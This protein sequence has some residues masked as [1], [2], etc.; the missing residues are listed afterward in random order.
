M[1]FNSNK[2]FSESSNENQEKLN[3]PSNFNNFKNLP[4]NKNLNSINYNNINHHIDNIN[5][6][7]NFDGEAYENYKSS[8]NSAEFNKCKFNIPSQKLY[9]NI[10]NNINTIENYNVEN[11]YIHT[12]NNRNND[13]IINDEI[14]NTRSSNPDLMIS[15]KIKNMEYNFIEYK[16]VDSKTN[17]FSTIK[18]IDLNLAKDETFNSSIK[19]EKVNREENKNKFLDNS[20]T[21]KDSYNNQIKSETNF[22]FN[23]ITENIQNEK[24]SPN[25]N[26]KK[27]ENLDLNINNDFDDNYLKYNSDFNKAL[28]ISGEKLENKIL[29][30]SNEFEYDFEHKNRKDLSNSDYYQRKNSPNFNN[31]MMNNFYADTK[32]I[33]GFNFHNN[34][35]NITEKDNENEVN[36]KIFKNKENEINMKIENSIIPINESY[37]DY[38]NNYKKDLD[39]KK[40]LIDNS[41]CYILFEKLL[42][43]FNNIIQKN[44]GYY[45]DNTISSIRRKIEEI[46]N[47]IDKEIP[48]PEGLKFF[49]IKNSCFFSKMKQKILEIKKKEKIF[50]SKLENFKN[51]KDKKTKQKVLNSFKSFK[52][53]IVV[54]L[55]H[56]RR[57]L[58]KNLLW[59][60]VLKM[61]LIYLIIGNVLIAGNYMLIIKE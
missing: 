59:Y 45:Y 26:L 2:L 52:Y 24:N 28:K 58:Q 20:I 57:E 61:N 22:S 46:D 21:P 43:L 35:K 10:N 54:W 51:Y 16:N 34:L 38:L 53:Q 56:T 31:D 6:N 17:N 50:K 49:K 4:D 3:S 42:I 48:E 40:R 60:F 23:I 1:S 30:E 15:D 27:S 39:L 36:K 18:D 33:H 29:N 25:L 5:L 44:I 14:I 41:K 47:F 8:I 32:K 13:D 55:S 7:E 12:F 9:E 37:N 11:E 19:I